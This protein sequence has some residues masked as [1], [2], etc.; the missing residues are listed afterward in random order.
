MS[1]HVCDSCILLF[2][3]SHHIPLHYTYYMYAQV[4]PEI[5]N[6]YRENVG[7][8]SF[9][10]RPLPPTTTGIATT[11]STVP[12]TYRSKAIMSGRKVGTATTG[13]AATRTKYS[14]TNGTGTT[15]APATAAV[16]RNRRT[17]TT[18]TKPTARTGTGTRTAY[19]SKGMTRKRS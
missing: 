10:R 16:T 1:Q 2:T 19:K 7:L 4:V 15:T 11:P 9:I 17:T 6:L 14:S 12:A 3:P 13:S 8:A 5:L 18:R